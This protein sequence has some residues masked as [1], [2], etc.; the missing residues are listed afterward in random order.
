[1]KHRDLE[2]RLALL[3]AIVVLIGVSSA[4]TSAFAADNSFPAENVVNLSEIAQVTAEGGRHANQRIADAALE[5]ITLNNGIDLDIA[6]A[7]RTSRLIAD[8]N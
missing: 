8:A 7:N 2:N 4:A 3:G 5:A 1:M 6:F